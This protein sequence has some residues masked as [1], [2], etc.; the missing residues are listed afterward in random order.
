V[1]AG[2]FYAGLLHPLI[3]MEPALALLSLGLAC[4]QIGGPRALRTA[5]LF[6]AAIAAGGLCA[7]G[8]TG[9][10]AV[11]LWLASSLIVFGLGVATH[12]AP[13]DLLFLPLVSLFGAA[14]GFSLAQ[15]TMALLRAPLGY[16]GGMVLTAALV[17]FYTA[18][19]VQRFQVFFVQVGVRI[20]GSWVSAI[21]AI[22]LAMQFRS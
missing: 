14:H 3:H 21:G 1:A 15:G 5:A 10:P 18:R 7:L 9:F 6:S 4:G 17:L 13:H 22:L 8:G 11:S 20:A 16:I 19:F 2:D 12:R